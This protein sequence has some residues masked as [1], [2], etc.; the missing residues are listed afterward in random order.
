MDDNVHVISSLSKETLTKLIAFILATFFKHHQWY[1]AKFPANDGHTPLSAHQKWIFQFP[2]TKAVVPTAL[3]S[4]IKQKISRQNVI[5][6]EIQNCTVS[7][8]SKN[9]SHSHIA[10]WVMTLMSSSI[11][12][13]CFP[14]I[15]LIKVVCISRKLEKIREKSMAYM[16]L[17]TLKYAFLKQQDL[18]V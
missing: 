4:Y 5:S 17:H 12:F 15:T 3:P 14:N 18:K 13:Q 1:T 8:S 6:K 11:S 10:N 7:L 16:Q 9:L 2:I